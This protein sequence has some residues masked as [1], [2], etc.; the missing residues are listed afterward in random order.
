[1]IRPDHLLPAPE[2]ETVD[3]PANFRVISLE[4][5]VVMKLMLNR[6]IDRTHILDLIGVQL[7]DASWVAKLPPPLVERLQQLL[8][9]PDG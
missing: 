4:S 8:D 9:S 6:E 3:D 7:I 2:I 1:M 5:L